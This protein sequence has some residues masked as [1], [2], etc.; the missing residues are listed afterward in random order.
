MAVEVGDDDPVV[1]QRGCDDPVTV[2]GEAGEEHVG[3]DRLDR[4]LLEVDLADRAG[5]SLG[6]IHA[7]VRTQ[8]NLA[9]GIVGEGVLF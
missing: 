8:V 7:P 2:H 1:G 4:L 5:V 9:E 3:D 6:R